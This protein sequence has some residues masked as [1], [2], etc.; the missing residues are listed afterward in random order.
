MVFRRDNEMPGA[1]A[2]RWDGTDFRGKALDEGVFVWQAEIEF[3]DGGVRLYSGD[4]T[5]IRGD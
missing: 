1:E 3:I 2:L 4:V 5:L